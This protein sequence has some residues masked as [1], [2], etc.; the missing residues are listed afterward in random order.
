MDLPITKKVHAQKKAASPVCPTCMEPIGA[1]C[2]C[3]MRGGKKI[4]RSNTAI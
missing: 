3:K 1:G 2:K 4:Q